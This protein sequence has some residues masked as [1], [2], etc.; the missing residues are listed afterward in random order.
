MRKHVKR[1]IAILLVAVL[2]AT[3]TVEGKLGNICLS[4]AAEVDLNLSLTV[5]QTM[6]LSFVD[7]KGVNFD[8]KDASADA[9]IEYEYNVS[10]ENIITVMPK[11]AGICDI[12]AIA[13]SIKTPVKLIIT[14]TDHASD[15]SISAVCEI[16]VRGASIE[17]E[18][19]SILNPGTVDN[20]KT[21]NVT[22]YAANV[23]KIPYV[24]NTGVTGTFEYEGRVYSDNNESL[25]SVRYYLESSNTSVVSPVNNKPMSAATAFDYRIYGPGKATLTLKQELRILSKVNDTG[26]GA[27]YYLADPTVTKLDEI[28]VTVYDNT[29]TLLGKNKITLPIGEN[30][31]LNLSGN[32]IATHDIAYISSNTKI[33]KVSDAGV[34]TGVKAGNATVTVTDNTTAESFKVNVSVKNATINTNYKSIKIS[35]GSKLYK[36]LIKN[37]ADKA[38]YTFKS[39]KTKVASVDK[40]GVIKAV[41]AGSA[42]IKVTEKLNNKTRNLG[43]ITVKVDALCATDIDFIDDLYLNADNK[44]L[45]TAK[46]TVIKNASFDIKDYIEADT[47]LNKVKLTFKSSNPKIAKAK[48]NGLVEALSTGKTHITVKSGSY[49]T[50]IDV[51]VITREDYNDTVA[52]EVS[53]T[54]A[55]NAL[56]GLIDN[57]YSA[58]TTFAG[59][60]TLSDNYVTAYDAYNKVKNTKIVPELDNFV[61][62]P[63][64]SLLERAEQMLNYCF[65]RDK[66]SYNMKSSPRLTLILPEDMASADPLYLSGLTAKATMDKPFTAT[67]VLYYCYCNKINYADDTKIE[68]KGT[69]DA[70]DNRRVNV[71]VEASDAY[72]LTI[73]GDGRTRYIGSADEHPV[74]ASANPVIRHVK[75]TITVSYIESVRSDMQ[76]S[77]Y[78]KTYLLD[79]EHYGTAIVDPS[80]DYKVVG[81]LT[82]GED[83]FIQDTV[84]EHYGTRNQK[85][86]FTYD[87]VNVS[88]PEYTDIVSYTYEPY[89]AYDTVD[90]TLVIEGT[91][92]NAVLTI[93]PVTVK[94]PINITKALFTTKNQ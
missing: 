87:I 50:A 16:E 24:L 23:N 60:R 83:I 80:N 43:N 72:I 1:I 89:G 17:E 62:V 79:T 74:D 61:P 15:E 19:I 9:D 22:D 34:I 7:I 5:G 40:Y 51:N 29:L 13:P 28:N 39:N 2:V 14:R 44:P 42:T 48:P 38:T 69:F 55:L 77:R 76:A 85:N 92:K 71:D 94:N 36:N 54:S 30:E 33:A 20:M 37:R 35:A 59:M 70:V 45:K 25:F 56:S 81:N 3:S 75:Q 82:V 88:E 86:Y 91:G 65:T 11:E 31:K 21:L 41:K 10:D 18:A 68:L 32:G 84:Y 52:A 47:T 12:V 4:T 66:A 26:S 58:P 27:S 63:N 6:S 67:D 78:N 57:N 8:S 73:S 93:D 46:M 64:A 53:A 49:S 90:A